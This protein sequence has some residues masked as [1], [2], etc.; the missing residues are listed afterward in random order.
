MQFTIS[1]AGQVGQ[2]RLAQS[3][4]LWPLFETVVNSI[5]SL[6]DT[7]E[8]AK[9]ITVEARRDSTIQVKIGPDGSQT[10]E[11]SR[12][13]EFVVTDNGNGFN[14]E[15]YQSFLQAYSQF[16]SKEGLQRDWSIPLAKSF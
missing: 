3:K 9:R 14:S 6:E 12:F 4:A 11:P 8:S 16:E 2:I 10:E 1:V 5:Q 15:N 13:V 7:D